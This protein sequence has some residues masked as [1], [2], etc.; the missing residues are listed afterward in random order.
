MAQ[1]QTLSNKQF[2]LLFGNSTSDEV[3]AQLRNLATGVFWDV[4]HAFSRVPVEEC[5]KLTS[6]RY[7]M[8]L[9]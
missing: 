8:T 5:F 9:L 3:A 4:A 2:L 7:F 6:K 1:I